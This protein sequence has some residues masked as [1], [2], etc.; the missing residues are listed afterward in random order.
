MT[1]P[2]DEDFH[3]ALRR[4]DTGRL[5]DRLDARACSPDVFGRLV[6]HENLRIRYLGLTLLTER[7][8]SDH[9]PDDVE[10]A[11]F[12]ALLPG[13]AAGPPE[14]ALVLAG[15]YERL[16]PY[17]DGRPW[18]LWRAAQLPVRVRIAWLRA[19]L[20]N[21]PAMLRKEPPGELLYQA[22]RGA[23]VADA[24]RPAQ[25]VDELARSGDPVLTAAALRLARQGLHAGLLARR[26]SVNSWCGCSVP[27]TPTSP[28]RRSRRS[29]SHGRRWIRCRRSC[30]PLSRPG[31]GEHRTGRGRGGAHDRGPARAPSPAAAGRRRSRPVAGS[32]AARDG[33]PR[34]PGG[35]C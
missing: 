26:W 34:R 23:S 32:P 21:D 13:S 16:G 33:T 9:L 14:A 29:P 3:D 5:A 2:A 35:P 19:E 22:V 1:T 12:A 17:L 15:L 11:A 27:E 20:L 30:W 28:P 31:C 4:A 10:S 24:H 7:L 25:L 6:R 8:A 18:P